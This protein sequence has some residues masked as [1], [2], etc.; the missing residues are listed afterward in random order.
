MKDALAL[1][2]RGDDRREVVVEQ[3]NVGSFL[4]KGPMLLIGP[5]NYVDY[6]A[7]VCSGDAHGDADVG[8]L[9]RDAIVD[10]VPGDADGVAAGL[11]GGHNASL[12]EKEYFQLC[13][14]I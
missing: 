8:H 5:P 2:H 12:K 4:M 1:L 6:L 7:D 13:K 11:E 3:D 10:A 9:D 14:L